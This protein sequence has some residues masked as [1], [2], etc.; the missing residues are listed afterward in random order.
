MPKYKVIVNPNA[1]KGTASRHIPSIETSFQNRGLEYSI[2]ISER[3]WHAVELSQQAIADGYDT[4]VAAGGDGTINEVIN[5]I[6]L[7]KQSGHSTARLGVLPIGRGN[8]FAYA[9]GIPLDF[10]AS[11][12]AIAQAATRVIDVGRVTGGLYPQGRY[13]GNGVGVGF[14]AVINYLASESRIGGTLGYLIAAAK[15][16]F[17]YFKPPLVEIQLDDRKMTQFA[18]MVTAMNGHR[19]GGGFILAPDANLSDANFDVCVASKLNKFEIIKL[20][21]HFLNGSQKGHPALQFSYSQTVHVKAL[22]GILYSQADGEKISMDATEIT[23][24]LFPA[25]LEVIVP[26]N[27]KSK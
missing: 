13:F 26:V 12:E 10:E 14:D 22:E 11:C 2:A 3:P 16:I 27:G 21:P 20:L 1:A 6:M 18:M 17:F 19:L 23:I 9:A 8:D 4:I 7:S 24:E 5:G 25:Q 15:A